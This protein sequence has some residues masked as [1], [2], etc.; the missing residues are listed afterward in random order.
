MI[1][2]I[3]AISVGIT[4]LL[5]A[6]S[7]VTNSLHYNSEAD[8]KLVGAHLA[9]EGVEIVRNMVDSNFAQGAPW[10]NGFSTSPYTFQV[11]YDSA[12]P[13]TVQAGNPLYY[14]GGTYSYNNALSPLAV[15]SGFIRDITTT[16]HTDGA[17]KVYAISVS[18]TVRM[19]G[20]DPI[21]IEDHF[22]NWRQ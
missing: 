8:R 14:L 13:I 10:T 9:A 21:V 6:F 4:A 12:V 17:G 18:S 2:S 3:V 11:S 19:A 15:P 7:L 22:Y 16:L 1:E 5:S 20:M